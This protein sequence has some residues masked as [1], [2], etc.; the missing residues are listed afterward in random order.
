MGFLATGR[1]SKVSKLDVTT[2]VKQNIVR[3]DVAVEIVSLSNTE[4]TLSIADS[5][6]VCG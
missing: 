4:S 5:F 2:A 1:Q 6:A 3:L